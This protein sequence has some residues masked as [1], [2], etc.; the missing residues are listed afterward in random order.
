MGGVF[1]VFWGGK[2]NGVWEEVDIAAKN[3]EYAIG[4]DS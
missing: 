1:L 2:L 3:D 4:N